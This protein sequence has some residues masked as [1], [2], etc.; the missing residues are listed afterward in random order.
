MKV[1][2]S[3][4]LLLIRLKQVSLSSASTLAWCR[5]HLDPR[6]VGAPGGTVSAAG[7]EIDVA[8]LIHATQ[9]RI[10][11]FQLDD[12][13][14]RVELKPALIVEGDF[15]YHEITCEG[16]RSHHPALRALEGLAAYQQ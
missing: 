10:I 12:D 7:H 14:L 3:R 8:D 13:L 6:D 4:L 9:V 2:L 16:F 11:D 1:S 5:V 15:G